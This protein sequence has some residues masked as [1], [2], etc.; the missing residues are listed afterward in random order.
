[1][2]QVL[3]SSAPVFT[4]VS[5][6][7]FTVTFLEHSGCHRNEI[8]FSTP[9]ILHTCELPDNARVIGL[10]TT[11]S[12]HG[13]CLHN[14]LEVGSHHPAGHSASFSKPVPYSARI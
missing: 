8:Q 13:L 3:G 1:M 2:T 7:D 14:Q 12:S 9:G 6:V 10:R 11:L 5:T 4:T